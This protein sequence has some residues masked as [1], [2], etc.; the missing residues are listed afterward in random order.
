[1]RVILF[2]LAIL[3]FLAGFGILVAAK[4]AVHEIEAFVVYVVAAV[5]LSGAAIVDAILNLPKRL[6]QH[7]AAEAKKP[8]ANQSS[9]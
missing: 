2:I 8:Q 3:A 6:A 9:G 7:W 5:L 1:M 4:S